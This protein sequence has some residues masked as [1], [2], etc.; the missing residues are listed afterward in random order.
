M[1]KKWILVVLVVVLVLSLAACAPKATDK[2]SE[3]KEKG[4]IVACLSADYPPFEYVDANGQLA[5]FDVD[6]VNEI[7]KRMGV[8]VE[9][10]DMPFDSLVAAVQEGKIDL[11]ASAFNYSEDRDKMVDFTDP[12]YTS[13]DRFLVAESFSTEIKAPEDFAAF[14]IGAGTGTTQ[15][16]WLTENLVDAGLMPSE[17]LFRYDRAD[18]AALD[19]KAGRIDVY[20]GD[21]AVV[22]AL[23]AQLGG[24]KVAFEAEVSSGPI[25]MV[26]PDGAVELK[27]ALNEQI[28]AL[29]KDGFI[30]QLAIKHIGGSE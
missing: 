19:V 13:K 2:L 9:F 18:Q 7:A 21:N 6:L 14:K 10:V 22:D 16:A 27:A 30:D 8:K 25:M 17:N 29:L 28:N 3:I 24:L 12:Y 5:G 11:S 20:M 1:K 26:I 23:A 15:D 4:K